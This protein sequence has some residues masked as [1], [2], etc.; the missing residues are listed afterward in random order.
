MGIF[1][2][3]WKFW[4]YNKTDDKNTPFDLDL[5]LNNNWDK[6]EAE[7]NATFQGNRNINLPGGGQLQWGVTAN[8]FSWS[9]EMRILPAGGKLLPGGIALT[10]IK[11]ASGS[12]TLANAW[13][14]MYITIPTTDGA[15]VVPAVAQYNAIIG[16]D[17]LILAV[18]DTDSC[19]ELFAG[20]WLV[21]GT[22]VAVGGKRDNYLDKTIFTALNDFVVGTGAGTYA[23]K[24]LAETKTI[25]GIN[26]ATSGATGVIQ[27]ATSAEV[28]AGTDAVK[29]VTPITLK[30]ELDKKLD[31]SQLSTDG[32]MASNST[33]LIPSQSAVITYV[34]AKI[35]SL[36]NS[37]PTTL[38]TLQE[39]ATALGNDPNFATTITNLIGTKVAKADFTALNDILVGTGAGTYIK[40][41]PAEVRTVLNIADGANNYIHPSTHGQ[42]IILDDLN[43]ILERTIQVKAVTTSSII[44]NTLAAIDG[45]IPAAGDLILL[46]SS[47]GHIND[48]VYTVAASGTTW[49]RATVHN[50]EDLIVDRLIKVLNG[51]IYKNSYFT[52][53]NRGAITIGTTAIKMQQVYGDRTGAG[54]SMDN[55]GALRVSIQGIIS[56]MLANNLNLP[57]APTAATA[58]IGT[59]TTQVAN[60]QYVN[61]M[62]GGTTAPAISKATNGYV[63]MAN[64]LII[65]WGRGAGES[66][67][68][69]FPIVFPSECLN[70]VVSANVNADGTNY[71]YASKVKTTS[72]SGA[73]L[74]VNAPNCYWIAIGY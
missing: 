72:T 15:T 37:S 36:V 31:D 41:T 3:R 58:S 29:A 47:G 62:V 63:K 22:T 40:K 49:T 66:L 35:A 4:K 11:I 33:T 18:R 74:Y 73:T 46:A 6:L 60:C 64:G 21:Y 8:V 20:G 7:G 1:T 50:T 27:L 61:D 13:D 28:T 45:Y 34:L 67:S 32:T 48:G 69:T 17:K 68:V 54:L 9:K 14:C 2:N 70:V 38:D 10:N 51:T 42:S 23:K 30:V 71:S 55:K 52:C 65:Q 25:L 39:L 57:G 26:N 12:V 5:A 16:D 53:V 24:T 59:D 19:L 43:H 56:E 44:P